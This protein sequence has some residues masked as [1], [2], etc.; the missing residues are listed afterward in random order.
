MENNDVKN[1]EKENGDKIY[2]CSSQP[3]GPPPS[4]KVLKS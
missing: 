4:M 3:P 1:N 2:R